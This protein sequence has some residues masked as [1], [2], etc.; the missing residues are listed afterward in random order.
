MRMGRSRTFRVGAAGAALWCAAAFA[1]P[2]AGQAQDAKAII[3]Q[4]VHA[5]LDANANDHSHWRYIESEDGGN[6]FVVVETE[7]GAIKR[8]ID[9]GGHPA[10]EATLRADDEYNQRFIHDPSLREKQRANGAHDDRD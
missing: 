10:S 9:E 5:E 3:Q 7:N 2:Q 1:L 6:K 4:A 8:H